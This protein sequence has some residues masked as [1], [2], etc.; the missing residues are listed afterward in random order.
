M[1]TIQA[2]GLEV[3]YQAWGAGPPV[4]LLHGATG[5]GPSQMAGLAA[6]VAASMRAL[7]PDARG[8]AGTRWDL[9][10]GLRT[11]DLVDDVLAFADVLGLD[12]FHLLGYSMG[13]MTALTL[14]AEHGAR[15]RSL[16]LVSIAA[17][18]EPRLA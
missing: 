13:G 1:P 16:V 11:V 4:I 12:T 7:A 9:S 14:A 18:R 8:H 2:N 10:P 15:L 3:A 17:E 6:S 5:S